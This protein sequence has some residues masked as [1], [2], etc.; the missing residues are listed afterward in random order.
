MTNFN[1]GDIIFD[2]TPIELR[3]LAQYEWLQSLVKPLK[4]LKNDDLITYHDITVYDML[5]NGQVL[6][7]EHYLNN[8][9]MLP[10]PNSIGHLTITR[11]SIYIVDGERFWIKQLYIFNKGTD[12]E[13]SLNWNPHYPAGVNTSDPF[14]GQ[15]YTFNKSEIVASPS[16]PNIDDDLV[17]TYN[18]SDYENDEI[19]FIVL[20]WEDW[21]NADLTR[22]NQIHQIV[23]TYHVAGYK[24]AI[25][26]YN[27]V[28]TIL[29]TPIYIKL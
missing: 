8:H 14:D 28:G 3:T 18:K 29:D 12:A 5:H 24:W 4:T 6:S 17:A 25:M 15:S 26:T 22:I 11:P 27:T 7:M 23:E 20:V 21:I 13:S 10:F 2:V 16:H 9:F 19:D 1:Y